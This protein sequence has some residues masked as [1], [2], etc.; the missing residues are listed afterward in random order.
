[1]LQ[2]EQYCNFNDAPGTGYISRFLESLNHF[3]QANNSIPIT[4]RLPQTAK[5]TDETSCRSQ[6]SQPGGFMRGWQ[7]MHSCKKSQ[8]NQSPL[9]QDVQCLVPPWQV[10][11]GNNGL[12]YRVKGQGRASEGDYSSAHWAFLWGNSTLPCWDPSQL[13]WNTNSRWWRWLGFSTVSF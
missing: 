5:C 6:R 8:T 10:S 13:P 4:Y 7:K 1:M 11:K 2:P 12:C 3:L 9:V